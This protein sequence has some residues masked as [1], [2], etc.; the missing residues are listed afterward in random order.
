MTE[1]NT[2][3]KCAIWMLAQAV[4]LPDSQACLKTIQI[5]THYTD[6]YL[7]CNMDMET[8]TQIEKPLSSYCGYPGQKQHIQS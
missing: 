2:T 5:A 3:H 1:L 6:M 8:A 4:P 7:I